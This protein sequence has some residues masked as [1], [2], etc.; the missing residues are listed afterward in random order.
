MFL[1]FYKSTSCDSVLIIFKELSF[2][3]NPIIAKSENL[4]L[5]SYDVSISKKAIG[6]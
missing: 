6:N 5:K 1:F 3:S 2:L 4:K